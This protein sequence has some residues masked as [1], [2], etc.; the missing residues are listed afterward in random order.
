MPP[1]ND[2]EP[3]LTISTRA[4][5]IALMLARVH[6]GDGDCL[7]TAA[8]ELYAVLNGKVEEPTDFDC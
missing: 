6:L 4:A 7:G 1:K 8:R 5:S 3:E 2:S